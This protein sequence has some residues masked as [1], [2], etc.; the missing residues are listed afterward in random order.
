M[1]RW[2][3][4]V[5]YL[6]IEGPY[7]VSPLAFAFTRCPLVILAFLFSDACETGNKFHKNEF[8]LFYMTNNTIQWNKRKIQFNT[9]KKITGKQ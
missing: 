3:V 6:E 8:H 5:I 2:Y 4:V 7:S 1:L 9:I